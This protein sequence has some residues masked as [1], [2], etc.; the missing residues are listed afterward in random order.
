MGW[1]GIAM[2]FN[3]NRDRG[4]SLIY[5]SYT[6][7]PNYSNQSEAYLILATSSD[8]SEAYLILATS[9]YKRR[10]EQHSA[11]TNRAV[12]RRRRRRRRRR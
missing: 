6:C 10:D 11:Q 3:M 4:V 2:Y 12:R 1:V 8:Q 9:E 5:L 7:L